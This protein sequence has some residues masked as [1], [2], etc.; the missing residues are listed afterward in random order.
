MMKKLWRTSRWQII[1]S[2]L[3]AG[4]ILC[5]GLNSRPYLAFGGEGLL[6]VCVIGYW[7]YRLVEGERE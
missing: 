2:L 1:G 3:A 4:V 5:A 7:I 6:A